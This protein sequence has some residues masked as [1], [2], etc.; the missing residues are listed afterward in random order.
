MIKSY[1]EITPGYWYMFTSHRPGY[2]VVQVMIG[3]FGEWD[4]VKMV[5]T[6]G[7]DEPHEIEVYVPEQFIC[8]VPSPISL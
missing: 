4:G 8:E 5:Y 3:A 1:D 2:T 6:I 7:A